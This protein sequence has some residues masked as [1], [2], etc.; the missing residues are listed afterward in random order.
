MHG[1]INVRRRSTQHS[2]R[3]REREAQ[4]LRL[5]RYGAANKLANSSS[6]ADWRRRRDDD[7][8]I[9]K[10]KS[11]EKCTSVCVWIAYRIFIFARLDIHR[12]Y[13]ALCGAA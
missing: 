13:V 12:V 4:M 2:K 1:H 5:D 6:G 11:T 8:S 3:E 10:K 7:V 9:S